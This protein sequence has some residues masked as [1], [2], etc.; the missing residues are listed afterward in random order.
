MSQSKLC[1]V[2]GWLKRLSSKAAASDEAKHTWGPYGGSLSDV[3]TTLVGFFTILV[4]RNVWG[5]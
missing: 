2:A 5:R 1:G 4:G 3:R